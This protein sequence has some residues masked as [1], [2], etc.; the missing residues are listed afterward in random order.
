MATTE[1]WTRLGLFEVILLVTAKDPKKR[2]L[3]KFSAKPPA[4]EL[5]D[6]GNSSRHRKKTSP[7]IRTTLPSSINL[8]W[9][10]VLFYSARRKYAHSTFTFIFL[11][12][13]RLINFH[14]YIL[15][16]FDKKS[17]RDEISSTP[18]KNIHKLLMPKHFFA[19]RDIEVSFHQ[20]G[21]VVLSIK[22]HL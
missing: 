3:K 9:G 8:F 22:G 13:N 5:V 14:H 17:I 20:H 15:V 7:L 16:V 18:S 4:A 11:Q 12:V 1:Y 2:E 10:L 6:V 21:F 19:E